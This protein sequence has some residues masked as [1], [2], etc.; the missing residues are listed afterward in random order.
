M[1]RDER[2]AL[3]LTAEGFPPVVDEVLPAAAYALLLRCRYDGVMDDDVAGYELST[4]YACGDIAAGCGDRIGEELVRWRSRRAIV[5]HVDHRRPET[6]GH[7]VEADH[8]VVP[9]Y[10][11]TRDRTA[12]RKDH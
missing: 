11:K 8:R 3:A 2:D 10:S 4:V 6:R 7:V 9:A 1:R 12:D 5:D